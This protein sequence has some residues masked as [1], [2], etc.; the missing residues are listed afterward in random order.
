MQ[1]YYDVRHVAGESTNIDIDNGVVESATTS[2]FDRAVVRVLGPSGWGV[3]S[4]DNY[5][6]ADL[7][8][9]VAE[10]LALAERRAR[11]SL[12]RTRRTGCSPFL[13]PRTIRGRTDSR[14]RPGF[15][16]VSRPPRRGPRSGTP[17]RSTPNATRR[18]ASRP[19]KESNTPTRSRGRGTTCSPSPSETAWSRW[20]TSGG[21]PSTA[22]R[23][24]PAFPAARRPGR[25]R[26]RSSTRGPRRAGECGSCSTPSSPASSPTRR[27]ATPPR[28][29]WSARATRS[30]AGESASGSAHRV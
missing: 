11:R 17:A 3:V 9:F 7:D 25:P 30:S 24:G 29:T 20:G 13:R 8:R 16:P 15:W 18:S 26:S 2:L 10:A 14:R 12:S 23:S 21:T 5:R 19:R 22:F 4:V 28:G 6:G 1:R 27:S